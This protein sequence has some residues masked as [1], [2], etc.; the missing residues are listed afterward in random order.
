MIDK[1]KFKKIAENLRKEERIVSATMTN[2]AA[3]Y[4]YTPACTAME[5]GADALDFLLSFLPDSAHPLPSSSLLIGPEEFLTA[6]LQE[7]DLLSLSL[8]QIDAFA[9]FV[10]CQYAMGR[11]FS[12][13]E[14]VGLDIEP[15]A[16]IRAVRRSPNRFSMLANEI[17]LTQASR[18]PVNPELTRMA[19][20][21]FKKYLR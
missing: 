4:A 11:A 13:Y 2:S 21:F 19:K 16:V 10:K 7:S 18:P 12:E 17:A 9:Q 6:L 15:H 14:V 8:H 20:E 5:E 1:K 3:R